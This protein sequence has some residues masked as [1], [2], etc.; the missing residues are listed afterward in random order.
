MNG[1]NSFRLL[2]AV[3]LLGGFIFFYE[4]HRDSSDEQREMMRRAF[5]VETANV[6]GLR[7]RTPDYDVEVLLRNGEWQM[8][9]PV[10][11]RAQ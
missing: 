2:I 11:A 10:G 9:K 4:R 1:G 6:T 3:L 5:R 8:A 7:V